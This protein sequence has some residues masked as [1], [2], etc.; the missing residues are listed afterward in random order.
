M[1]RRGHGPGRGGGR[2]EER[3]RGGSGKAPATPHL[4]A[5]LPMTDGFPGDN[6]PARRVAGDKLRPTTLSLLPTPGAGGSRRG[7]KC[8]RAPVSGPTH[9]SQ[10]TP[11]CTYTS[12]D[13][14]SA[15]GHERCNSA[16]HAPEPVYR[17]RAPPVCCL[18]ALFCSSFHCKFTRT[19]PELCGHIAD[20]FRYL[21][22][23][24]R[25]IC[26]A[27]MRLK[28]RS[29]GNSFNNSVN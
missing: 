7:Q 24:A 18:H 2:G 1:S 23:D 14:T 12:P 13:V 27:E 11:D 15:S 10:M 19:E 26:N 29:D 22:K 6:V 20:G 4:F 25:C 16:Q 21:C 28:I 8:Q 9:I 17:M 3:R 5:S